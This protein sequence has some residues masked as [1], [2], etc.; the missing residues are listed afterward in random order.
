MRRAIEFQ[1]AS[2]LHVNRGI[3]RVGVWSPKDALLFGKEYDMTDR[4][5]NREPLGGT[6]TLRL[7]GSVQPN[8][9]P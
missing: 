1:R 3:S 2:V 4:L 9:Q 6:L 7:T 5:C 8:L